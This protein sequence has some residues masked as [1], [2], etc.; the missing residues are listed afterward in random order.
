MKKTLI[1]LLALALSGA[2]GFHAQAQ[3][4]VTSV[5]AVGM[6][7][8]TVNPGE[9]TLLSLPFLVDE[10]STA[11]DI[12]GAVPYGTTIY[13]WE[14]N[15]WVTE[16]YSEG[17]P[18]LGI[19]DAWEPGF[20]R[21][22]NHFQRGDGI[23]IFLPD[24]SDSH[25]ITLTGEVPGQSTAPLTVQNISEGFSLFGFGYPVPL[26]ISDSR[27]DL[28]PEYNDTIFVW[29]NG[30]ETSIYQEGVPFLG[31]EDGWESDFEI[32]PAGAIFYRTDSANSLSIEKAL[33]YSFP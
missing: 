18:F 29:N 30:W 3:E 27:I 21:E 2:A 33:L 4:T 23:F 32:S 28:Q 6:V 16:I 12:F 14:D 26:N 25:D 1:P 31:I 24:N 9:F 19:P 22:L 7:K 17:I 11:E 5:N 10:E 13:F 20:G 8:I 15:N